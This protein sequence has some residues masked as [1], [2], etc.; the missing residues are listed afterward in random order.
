MTITNTDGPLALATRRLDDA[1][2]S[3]ADP[4]PQWV[5]GTCRWQASVYVRLRGALCARPV[6]RTALQRSRPPC[7]TAVL[8]LLVDIDAAVG[9]W[10]PDGTWIGYTCWPAAAGVR[11]IVR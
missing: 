7:N 9:A 10:A 11:R 1:V 5:D 6:G 3:M 4:A 8:A 2:H